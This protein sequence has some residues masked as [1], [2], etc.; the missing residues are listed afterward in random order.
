LVVVVV[1]LVLL[2][3]HQH[4]AQLVEL[5]LLAHLLHVLVGVVEL[6]EEMLAVALQLAEI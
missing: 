4:L 1:V 5:Q 3:G 2:V 6:P